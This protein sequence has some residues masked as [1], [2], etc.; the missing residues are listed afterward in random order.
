ME[1]HKGFNLY[2]P[3]KDEFKIAQSKTPPPITVYV[4][5]PHPFAK[6]MEENKKIRSL[7]T[8]GRA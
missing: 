3:K 1:A 6:R 2:Q 4:P 5:E 8:G 7:W